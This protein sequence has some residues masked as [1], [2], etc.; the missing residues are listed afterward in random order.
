MVIVFNSMIGGFGWVDLVWLTTS[1]V[2]LQ[3]FWAHLA[4]VMIVAFARASSSE[5]EIYRDKKGSHL[6]LLYN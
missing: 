3:K 5:V 6:F 2:R 4:S 1:T